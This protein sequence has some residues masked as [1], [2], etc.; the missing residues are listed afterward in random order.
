MNTCLRDTRT[1]CSRERGITKGDWKLGS[2]T[3]VSSLIYMLRPILRILRREAAYGWAYAADCAWVISTR[4]LCYCGLCDWRLCEA[5]RQEILLYNR[6]GKEYY[7]LCLKLNVG[8][9]TGDLDLNLQVWEK[10]DP[11]LGSVWV[12]L[13]CDLNLQVRYSQNPDWLM[14]WLKFWKMTYKWSE[15]ERSHRLTRVLQVLEPIWMV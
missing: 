1:T 4:I 9:P 6:K 3:E 11:W 8:Q 13:N 10:L 2:T 12:N 14:S 15:P 5:A 7:Q